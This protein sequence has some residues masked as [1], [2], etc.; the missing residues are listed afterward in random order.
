MAFN[1]RLLM[2]KFW[3]VKSHLKIS[4]CAWRASA[5]LKPMWFKG[6]QCYE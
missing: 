1:N 4:K 2:V 3:G 5:P 6:Q